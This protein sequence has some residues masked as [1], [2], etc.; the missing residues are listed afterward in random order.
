MSALEGADQLWVIRHGETEWS[1]DG[2]HTGRT[3]IPLT[4][5]GRDRA[6]A[7]SERVMAH[8]FAR[9]L[10]SPLGRAQETALLAGVGERAEAR[11]DL[12]EWHY[13]DDEGVSTPE[14]RKSRPGWWLWRDGAQGGETAEDVGARVDRIIDEVLA[15]DGDVLLVAHGHVLRVLAARWMEQPASFG[16]RLALST[17]SL[18]VLGFER[19]VRVVHRWNDTT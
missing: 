18:S 9:V 2:R 16:A 8:D 13:G 14:I 3:D 4:D 15:V 19:E 10:A 5:A 7:V 12:L 6:R 11:D 1:R 17:G